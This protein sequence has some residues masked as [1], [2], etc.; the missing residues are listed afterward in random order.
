MPKENPPI[1][2]VASSDPQAEQKIMT[3]GLLDWIYTGRVK[4][5]LI[6]TNI[7]NPVVFNS[8]RKAMPSTTLNLDS[9]EGW[10]K[11]VDICQ[12]HSD[13]IIVINGTT[14][15]L[16]QVEQHLKVLLKVLPKLDRYF[17]TFWIARGSLDFDIVDRY[18]KATNGRVLHLIRCAFDWEDFINYAYSWHDNYEDKSAHV[19]KIKETG[20]YQTL[21]NLKPELIELILDRQIP[22]RNIYDEYQSNARKGDPL[23]DA[24][25]SDLFGWR[26]KCVSIFDSANQAV[27]GFYS[28]QG[29]HRGYSFDQFA[30]EAA[31]DWGYEDIG[32]LLADNQMDIEYLCAQAVEQE[33]RESVSEIGGATFYAEWER[34]KAEF[35]MY[36]TD[37]ERTDRGQKEAREIAFRDYWMGRPTTN[38]I[39]TAEE[40][41]Q[42]KRLNS[43]I[44]F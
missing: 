13:R 11:L 39:P 4:C 41:E 7:H 19:D 29:G 9:Q 25:W 42:I 20:I 26:S 28:L 2:M 17:I 21:T 5:F 44:P 36:E 38:F 14:S 35:F 8:Y 12:Q 10:L 43:P 1:Y 37:E 18:I 3:V 24:R 30:D 22:F 6:D 34:R 27:T 33:E 32:D 23:T 16:G 31:N 40:L 15:V